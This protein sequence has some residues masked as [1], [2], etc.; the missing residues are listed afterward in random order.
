MELCEKHILRYL[1]LLREDVKT[2][3]PVKS[4]R[5]KAGLIYKN[6][7]LSFGINRMKSHPFQKKFGKNEDAI[8]LHAEIDCIINALRNNMSLDEISKSTLLVV[9]NKRQGRN[10]VDGLAKPCL[11]CQ[12]AISHFDIRNVIYTTDEGVDFL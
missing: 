10:W 1:E 12:K 6:E 5:I 3:E 2:Q 7:L 11:G 8:Y 9:R 4:S